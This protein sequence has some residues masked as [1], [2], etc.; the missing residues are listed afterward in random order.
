MGVSNTPLRDR[1]NQ[2][3]AQRF[4]VLERPQVPVL[5]R[6]ADAANAEIGMRFEQDWLH[7]Q[8]QC[9]L[10]KPLKH[11]RGSVLPRNRNKAAGLVLKPGLAPG[12]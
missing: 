6:V 11:R 10:L 7:S 1:L 5:L 8:S 12:R 2:E 4:G 9:E 3:L